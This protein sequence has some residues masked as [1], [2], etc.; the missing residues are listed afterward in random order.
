MS[1]QDKIKKCPRCGEGKILSGERSK[2]NGRDK[3][4]K[5]VCSGCIME[6]LLAPFV[7]KD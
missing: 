1:N 3:S 2:F 5:Q 6:D 7:T 4:G